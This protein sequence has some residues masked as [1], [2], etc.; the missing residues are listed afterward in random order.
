LFPESGPS[1]NNMLLS[2]LIPVFNEVSTIRKVIER[3]QATPY[4]KQIIVVDDF[5]T[6]G[7]REELNKIQDGN[8]EKYFHERNQGKGSAIRTAWSRA[9]GEVIVIQDA[10]LE[11]DPQDYQVLL[12]PILEGKADVV[13]GS[14]FVGYPRRV[15]YF[16]HS[17]GNQFLTLL[18][19]MLNDLN[20]SDMETC[21]K[22]FTRDV[23]DSLT[24]QSNRFGF[25]PEFTAKVAKKRFRIYEV[26]I[27]YAG[28]GYKEG[29]KITW[30]DG[31][32][33]LYWIFRYRFF[34]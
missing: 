28:R 26:P 9:K 4:E 34:N 15:L 8:V 31:F 21:Y 22:A 29:K 32:A 12:P 24:V 25:E 6:D 11:Y 17:L 19:N 30:K 23:R 33:A 7:T 27:S 1:F 13:F 16:W 10:D 14:R 20:L 3:V 5:S 2:V 18:A